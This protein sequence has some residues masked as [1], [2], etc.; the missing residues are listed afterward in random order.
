MFASRCVNRG[1]NI[2]LDPCLKM[3]RN[4]RTAARSDGCVEWL[5]EAKKNKKEW[6]TLRS[7]WVKL[8]GIVSRARNN[9]MCASRCICATALCRQGVRCQPFGR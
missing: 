2:S 6:S 1:E 3:L 4:L 9:A 8:M 5:E 7:H